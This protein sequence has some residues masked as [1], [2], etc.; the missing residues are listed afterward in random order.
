MGFDAEPIVLNDTVA[1]R[2]VE[3]DGDLGGLG[4]QGVFQEP[5]DDI[6]QRGDG[7]RRLDPV[8]GVFTEWPDGHG[9]K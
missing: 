3:T 9:M 6:V 8:N 4:V 5:T 7:R 1:Q 2:K